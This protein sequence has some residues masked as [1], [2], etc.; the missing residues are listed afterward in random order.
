MKLSP[1]SLCEEGGQ[2]AISSLNQMGGRSLKCCQYLPL[3]AGKAEK[4]CNPKITLIHIHTL[5]THL[6][7]SPQQE[8][9]PS[10][11]HGEGIF[12]ASDPSCLPSSNQRCWGWRCLGQAPIYE[13][14][15]HLHSPS[16]S[17]SRGHLGGARGP[18]K[19]RTDKGSWS[20][21]IPLFKQFLVSLGHSHLD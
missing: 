2:V 16:S 12:S 4:V 17:P 20:L 10:Q 5:H 15:A 6:L 7:W 18:E 21:D 11:P 8:E 19:G 13:R 9:H 3:G 14:G 1:K